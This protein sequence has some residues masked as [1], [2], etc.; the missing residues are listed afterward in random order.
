MLFQM[1]YLW[2]FIEAIT[3]SRGQCSAN[4]DEQILQWPEEEFTKL[5]F[6]FDSIPKVKEEE[7]EEKGACY[8][9]Q[10]WMILD[11]DFYEHIG[12]DERILNLG[13]TQ[14]KFG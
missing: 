10:G 5:V 7:E 13:R 2:W 1:L 4:S 11:L 3:A 12:E 14:D 9:I 8:P 6:A